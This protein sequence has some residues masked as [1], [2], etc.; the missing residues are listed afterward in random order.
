GLLLGAGNKVVVSESQV[1]RC[2]AADTGLPAS[3][4]VIDG[5]W[6]RQELSDWKDRIEAADRRISA[7]E[8]ADADRVE[9]DKYLKEHLPDMLKLPLDQ[10]ETESRKLVQQFQKERRDQRAA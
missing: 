2:E 3:V 10:Q 1:L 9:F 4:M 8:V 5:R 7:E 6:V